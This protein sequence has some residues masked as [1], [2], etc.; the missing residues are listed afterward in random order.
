MSVIINTLTIAIRQ[1]N[2]FNKTSILNINQYYFL[3]VLDCV[4]IINLSHIIRKNREK[5]KKIFKNTPGDFHQ[6]LFFYKPIKGAKK[7]SPT[8]AVIFLFLLYFRIAT[9]TDD[10]LIRILPDHKLKPNG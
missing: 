1:N 4:T 7:P 2:N 8:Q 6:L 3:V 5:L 9:K 10:L